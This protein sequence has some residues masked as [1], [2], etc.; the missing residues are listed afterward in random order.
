MYGITF[1]LFHF[2]KHPFGFVLNNDD[3]KVDFK[4]P[5]FKDSES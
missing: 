3:S 4:V 1:C 2:N 5:I